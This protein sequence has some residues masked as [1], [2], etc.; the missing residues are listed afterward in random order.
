MVLGGQQIRLAGISLFL[1][2][3]FSN[4]LTVIRAG[5]FR[6]IPRLRQLSL[7]DNQIHTIHSGTF[8]NLTALSDL[9]MFRNN[10]VTLEESWFDLD[11]HQC[12]LNIETPQN[13][14]Q[15]DSRMCWLKEVGPTLPSPLGAVHKLCY[16]KG[17]RG[18]LAKRYYWIFLLFKV[19]LNR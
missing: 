1:F 14:L 16:A 6:G 7:Y 17:G 12:D 19:C 18:G 5:L 3:A 2:F 10:L 15:C 4:N 9:W 11:N 13:P 8:W